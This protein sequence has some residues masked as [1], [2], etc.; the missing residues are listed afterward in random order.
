MLKG[1]GAGLTKG[2]SY[3]LRREG[4]TQERAVLCDDFLSECRVRG[5]LNGEF[6]VGLEPPP[7]TVTS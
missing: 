4:E 6:R 7:S 3:A 5:S 1:D 2:R